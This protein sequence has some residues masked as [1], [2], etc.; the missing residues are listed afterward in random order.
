MTSWVEAGEPPWRSWLWVGERQGY[1]LGNRGKLHVLQEG[2][3]STM[4]SAGGAVSDGRSGE[5]HLPGE[6]GQGQPLEPSAV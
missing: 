1:P 3:I 2:N 5:H 6:G 4:M